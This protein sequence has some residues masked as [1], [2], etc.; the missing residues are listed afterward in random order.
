[1]LDIKKLSYRLVLE[2]SAARYSAVP[3]VLKSIR[4]LAAISMYEARI[5]I[6]KH[7]TSK[8]ATK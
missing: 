7:T 1:M 4:R 5:R 6:E 8:S 2:L 3:D